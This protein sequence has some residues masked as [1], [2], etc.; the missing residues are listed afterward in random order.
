MCGRGK[1]N[2][3]HNGAANLYKDPFIHDPDDVSVLICRGRETKLVT[4]SSLVKI[5]VAKGKEEEKKVFTPGERR[6]M[7][8]ITRT[9]TEVGI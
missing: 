4:F 1:G 3:S 2:S 5:H 7:H 6:E 8:P 9:T